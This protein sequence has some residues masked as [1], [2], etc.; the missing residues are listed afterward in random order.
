MALK[1]WPTWQRW[2]EPMTAKPDSIDM[3]PA[4]IERRLEQVRAL[5]ALMVSLRQIRVDRTR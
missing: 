2:K 5:Y 1:T 4:A 3:S